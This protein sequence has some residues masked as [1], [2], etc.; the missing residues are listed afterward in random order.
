MIT[1]A[2][3]R[4]QPGDH[5]CWSSRAHTHEQQICMAW[6]GWLREQYFMA[7]AVAP[8]ASIEIGV[9]FKDIEYAV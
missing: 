2:M 1:L 5:K 6:G 8:L 3:S 9:K 7:Q 4:S